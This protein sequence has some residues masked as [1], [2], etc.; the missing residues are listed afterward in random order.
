MQ[1]TA[2]VNGI[3]QLVITKLDVLDSFDELRVCVGYELK[4]KRL[5]SFPTDITTLEQVMPVYEHCE[6]WNTPLSGITRF[7]DLPDKARG[8]VAALSRLSGTPIQSVS[9]GPHREQSIAVE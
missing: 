6:G 3:E 8:Y 2:M 5:K 4:G 7:G 1:Y 9:V